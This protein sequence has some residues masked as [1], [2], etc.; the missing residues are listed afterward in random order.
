M[1]ILPRLLIS[2]KSVPLR[3]VTSAGRN[4][5]NFGAE[6]HQSAIVARRQLEIGNRSIR[7]SVR[8]EREE[9]ATAQFFIGAGVAEFSAGGALQIILQLF[10]TF[11]LPLPLQRSGH[12]DRSHCARAWHCADNAKRV[13][14]VRQR[15]VGYRSPLSMTTRRRL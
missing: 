12:N 1:P 8:I 2:Y 5:R 4:T 13:D 14:A 11:S 3:R 6:F 7:R 10:Q 15:T 9:G